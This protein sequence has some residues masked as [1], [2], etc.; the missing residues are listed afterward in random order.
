MSGPPTGAMVC[1]ELTMHS[2]RATNRLGNMKDQDSLLALRDSRSISLRRCRKNGSESAS[3]D[4]VPTDEWSSR[5]AHH[6]HR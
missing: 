4:L 2:V 6:G 1:S 5:R 3:S